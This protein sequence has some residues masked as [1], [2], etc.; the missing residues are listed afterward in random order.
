MSTVFF[1]ASRE[2]DIFSENDRST[3][4]VQQLTLNHYNSRQHRSNYESIV[5]HLLNSCSFPF[6]TL[7]TDKFFICFLTIK[8]TLS[9]LNINKS[10]SF[11][12][13]CCGKSLYKLE[14]CDVLFSYLSWAYAWHLRPKRR[15][16]NFIIPPLLWHWVSVFVVSSHDHP[17]F[18]WIKSLLDMHK[19]TDKPEHD[20]WTKHRSECLILF[21]TERYLCA[22]C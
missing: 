22:I 6:V 17:T 14:W 19:Q 4:N 10:I 1:L 15:Q 18:A 13:Y 8:N 21:C 11:M 7:S 3:L 9:I 5:V 2:Y 12:L 16:K 20:I